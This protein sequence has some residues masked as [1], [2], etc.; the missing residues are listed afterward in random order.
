MRFIRL[1]EVKEKT[2]LSRT[3]IYRY[4]QYGGFPTQIQ[5]G[6]RAVCWLESEVD[7]WMQ[8]LYWQSSY[9]ERNEL[10]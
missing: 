10:S 9:S 2:G 7:K 3:C 8:G 5:I 4:M 1:K 6:E